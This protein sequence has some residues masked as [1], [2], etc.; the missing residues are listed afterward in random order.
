MRVIC[1]ESTTW[2]HGVPVE[3]LGTVSIQKGNIYHVTG[4]VDGETIRKE[5]NL[6]FAL[7]TWYELLE[8]PGIHHSMRFLE[9]PDDDVY[10]EQDVLSKELFN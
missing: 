6:P 4:S 10:K 9:I 1:I 7:G 5:T 2:V 3:H 8:V